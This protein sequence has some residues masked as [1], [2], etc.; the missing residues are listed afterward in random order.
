M[1]IEDLRKQIDSIDDELVHLFVKRMELSKHVANYKKEHNLP[2]YVPSRECEVLQKVAKKSGPDLEKYT[3]E[4]Y[5]KIFELSRNYQQ[6]N[7]EV[8]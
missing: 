7:T 6:Q 3:R 8:I 5:S 1:N 4:L 2:I